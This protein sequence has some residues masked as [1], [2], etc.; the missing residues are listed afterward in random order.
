MTTETTD[1]PAKPEVLAPRVSTELAMQ[2]RETISVMANRF[3]QL[4]PISGAPPDDAMAVR[5]ASMALAYGLDPALGHIELYEGKPYPTIDAMVAWADQHPQYDGY[6]SRQLTATEAQD[7][8][9]DADQIVVEVLVH[10]KDRRFPTKEYG[11]ASA[12]K[13]FRNNK[14]EREHPHAFARKRAL[15]RGIRRGLPMNMTAARSGLFVDPDRDLLEQHDNLIADSEPTHADRDQ[16]SEW[17]LFWQ[18]ATAADFTKDQV[19]DRIEGRGHDLTVT[20]PDT[21][22]LRKS[23]LAFTGTPLEA[24][25]ILGLKSAPDARLT[26]ADPD[27]ARSPESRL[28]DPAPNAAPPVEAEQP[29]M[30]SRE[31][32]EAEIAG[33]QSVTAVTAMRSL[34]TRE[35]PDGH[36]LRSAVGPLFQARIEQIDGGA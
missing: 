15:Y 20:D 33:C 9:Y 4:N 25:D 30:Q 27:A 18:L 1:A 5:M 31:W 22:E 2:N 14:A 12:T 17:S 29:T 32:W 24:L 26:A 19:Y 21:G 3:K 11:T 10:R 23:M 36:P 8:G 28:F 13:P 35:V 7:L 34:F 16:G 6:E